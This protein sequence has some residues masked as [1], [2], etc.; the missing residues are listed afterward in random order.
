MHSI[1]LAPSLVTTDRR[2][3]GRRLA[4]TYWDQRGKRHHSEWS[5]SNKFVAGWKSVPFLLSRRKHRIEPAHFQ[6][7]S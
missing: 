6:R 7:H 3:E 1:Q 5:A 2:I 4:V